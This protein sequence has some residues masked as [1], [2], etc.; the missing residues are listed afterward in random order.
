MTTETDTTTPPANAA[1]PRPAA[2]PGRLTV[3]W[4]RATIAL[5]VVSGTIVF[6]LWWYWR[7][8]RP[9][10]DLNTLSTWLRQKRYAEA[11][12]A[13]R[14]RLRRSPQD[15]DSRI[16][17]AMLL[18][19]RN[20]LLGCARELDRVPYWWPKKAEARFRA[21]QAYLMI[22]RARDAEAE[23][24]AVVEADPLHAS[25]P[26]IFHDAGR[27]LLNL[28]ALEDRW[29]DAKV[30]L[31]RLYDESPPSD[32][33]GLLAM[34]MRSELERV[35]PLESAVQLRRFVAADP[36]DWEAV[37]ALAHAERQLGLRAEA[38][39]HLRQCLEARP[40]DSRAWRDYLS[41][42]R[43][44]GDTTGL[45][46][47]VERIPKAAETEP[48]VWNYRGLALEKH[49]DLRGAANAYREAIERNPFVLEYHYRLG[50][51]EERLG[52][53]REAK[54]HFRRSTELREARGQLAQAYAACLAAL[55]AP[56]EKGPDPAPIRRLA[57]L[58][59]T[60]GWSRAADGWRRLA[61]R[62]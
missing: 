35:A 55:Q 18:G 38:A 33:P 1:V 15:G 19:A 42:L 34:R 32:R 46:D 2:A 43:A 31:W 49:G 23:W 61:P 22:D 17:L 6:N 48:E 7:A 58:C 40:D 52:N 28:Y 36:A 39:A 50:V 3:P 21:G 54:E 9:V 16:L 4:R 12:P 27:A 26:D 5:L 20:D 47:A 45:L 29:D 8:T 51:A 30:V 13:L 56:G 44:A 10:P 14:E 57:A 41:L 37:R 62:P 11:E 24:L 60:L 25:P 59:D 53:R